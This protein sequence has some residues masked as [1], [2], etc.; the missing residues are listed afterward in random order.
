MGQGQLLLARLV[1]TSKPLCS[2]LV[3]E[4]RLIGQRRDIVEGSGAFFGPFGR[5]DKKGDALVQKWQAQDME[6]KLW[7][8][9]ERMVKEKGFEV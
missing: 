1:K 9:S 4:M 7:E 8:A 6:E 3:E 5:R 2:H